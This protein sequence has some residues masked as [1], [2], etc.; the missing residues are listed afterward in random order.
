MAQVPIVYVLNGPNLNLL[1]VREPE[2]YGHDTLDDIAGRLE[3]QARALG[4]EIDL[5]QSNHEG[6]LVDWLH[7]A[8][9]KGAKAV[10][11]NAGAFTHTSIALFDAIKSINVPVIEVHLSNPHTRDAFRH[12]SYVGQ[13]AKGTIAGF[14]AMSY[15][16]ALDA[17]AKL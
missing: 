17:A 8:N 1:G 10:L 14:G 2:V 12:K 7:E 13:A 3:D 4:L 16:L 6:H 9:A 11:L 5:R 15:T